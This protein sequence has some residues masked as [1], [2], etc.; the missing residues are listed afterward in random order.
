MTFT[1]TGNG[2]YFAVSVSELANDNYAFSIEKL[3]ESMNTI[4]LYA[5]P[6]REPWTLDRFLEE[7][8]RTCR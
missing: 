2:K 8:K 6:E 3:L 1:R 7:I 4:K 5:L